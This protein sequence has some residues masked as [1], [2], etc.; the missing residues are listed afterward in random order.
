MLCIPECGTTKPIRDDCE[1]STNA[2][3]DN[4]SFRLSSS[5][6]VLAARSS[7]SVSDVAA[8]DLDNSDGEITKLRERIERLEKEN[9]KLKDENQAYR[10]LEA[11]RSRL[12]DAESIGDN[13]HDALQN[14]E[15]SLVV[16]L[17]RERVQTDT[18]E[19]EMENLKQHHD[20][21]ASDFHIWQKELVEE[22][23]S[24]NTHLA[25]ALWELE[26]VRSNHDSLNKDHSQLLEK[27]ESL[28][29]RH[30]ALK[31]KYKSLEKKHHAIDV[32]PESH[33]GEDIMDDLLVNQL[34]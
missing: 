13:V 30:K 24:L 7:S 33:I 18:L 9:A 16:L 15:E 28:H 26:T 20:T 21:R 12:E 25:D 5:C 17:Q 10:K 2:S 32:T 1:L 27:Y 8:L 6:H 22:Q 31:A 23:S 14:C 4:G 11:A 34:Y 29:G 3:S 19:R